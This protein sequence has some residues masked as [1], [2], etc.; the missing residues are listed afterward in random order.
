MTATQNLHDF[1]AEYDGDYFFKLASLAA[2]EL[3]KN[4][5]PV[6]TFPVLVIN[7]DDDGDLTSVTF[8]DE[9]WSPDHVSADEHCEFTLDDGSHMNPGCDM[10]GFEEASIQINDLYLCA[11]GHYS[12]DIDGDIESITYTR[13]DNTG[14]FDLIE[15]IVT[16]LYNARVTQIN[17]Y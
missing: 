8:H 14:I 16:R 13:F 1:L 7:I 2:W 12:R 15:P 10:C 3:A 9:S 4:G 17:A 5:Y 11:H 6:P